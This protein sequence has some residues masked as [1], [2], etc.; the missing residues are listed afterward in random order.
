[1]FYPTKFGEGLANSD[2]AREAAIAANG[3]KFA[4]GNSPSWNEYWNR[5]YTDAEDPLG[6]GVLVRKPDYLHPMLWEA[7][8]D[9]VYHAE[10]EA[11]S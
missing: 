1:M 8:Q 5:G 7:Y 4:D 2:I 6:K 3:V 11:R 10:Q 9:G